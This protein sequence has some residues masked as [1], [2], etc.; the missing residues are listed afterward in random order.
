MRNLLLLS[1]YLLTFF[2]SGQSYPQDYFRSPLDIELAL[3]GT[4]GELRGNHYH[5]GMDIKTQGR[6]GLN[7]FAAAEGR[8]VRIKV[9]AYGYGNALY[10]AHPNGYTTVY[11]HLQ[12]FAPEIEAWV[13]TQQYA[14]KTFEVDLF[15]PAVFKYN[16]GDIIAKSGNSGGSGG[17][18]LHFEIRDTRT[19]ETINPALFGLPVKD[20]RKPVI[21]HLYATPITAGTVVNG[22]ASQQEIALT[23]LGNG[24]FKGELSASGVLGFIVHTSDQQDLSNNSNGIY[25]LTQFVN[26]TPT[27]TFQIERFA[28]DETRYINAHMDFGRYKRN[29]QLTHKSY[30]E[31]GDKFSAY[32][33]VNNRGLIA[34]KANKTTSVTLLIEDAWGNK[35]EIRLSVRGYANQT[36]TAVSPNEMKW[37]Q[38]NTIKIDDVR[39]HLEA[40]TLYNDAVIDVQKSNAC[41]RCLTPVYQIGEVTIPAHKRY[42]LSIHRSA[43]QKTDKLVWAIMGD[44][45]SAS[46][47]TTNWQGD[48]L[49][50]NPREFGRFAVLQDTIAPVIKIQNFNN[51]KA[52]AKGQ[53]VK[54]TATDNLSGITFYEASIDGN[55]VLLEHD[56]KRNLWWHTFDDTTLT[57]GSHTLTIIMK[58]EVGNTSTWQSV[59]TYNP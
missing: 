35:S 11:A 23:N 15:P 3:S 55:W 37:D 30:V 17:P 32:K 45:G 16:K 44:N 6:E 48:W 57:S 24:I 13:K 59:F 54:L 26:D 56:A 40:G 20:S 29:K 19:E 18:H 42:S 46:G 51:G 8:I 36:L 2:L 22:K 10:M 28:F 41:S 49:T 43:L 33:N 4:F 5:S 25:R 38:P 21:S 14:K 34:P 27:Y 53:Q 50:A 47:L 12:S 7:V 39:I 1:A 52:I 9:S 31:P 58:D